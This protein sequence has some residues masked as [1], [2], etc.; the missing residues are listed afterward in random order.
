[1]RKEAF[2]V[3]IFADM[4][5][6]TLASVHAYSTV[7]ENLAWAAKAGLEAM[8]VTDHTLG[9]NFQDAP[10]DWHFSCLKTIPQKLDGI[11]VFRG[12]EA[13][14]A[15]FQGNIETPQALLREMEW[16][17]ASAHNP[18][19]KA[20]TM[21]QRDEMWIGVAQ[22]PYVDVLGHTG[23][24]GYEY[25]VDRVIPVVKE[26]GKMVEIN[27]HSLDFGEKTWANCREIALACKKYQVPVVV[28]TDAHFCTEVGQVPQAVQLL[29]EIQF[30]KELIFNANRER[31]YSYMAKRTGRTFE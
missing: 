20:G 3:E 17:I 5:T 1:M 28:S 11:W 2:I 27:N 6:H 9:A 24:A 18:D 19:L 7:M 14:V 26:Q 12:M 8:A 16:V 30:P 25:H 21:E 29:E 10:M 4:H 22:N 31:F 15:D 23:R 13:N